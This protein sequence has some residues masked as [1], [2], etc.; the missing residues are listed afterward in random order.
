V[1][2]EFQVRAYGKHIFTCK[3]VCEYKRKLVCGIHVES[4]NPPE[5]PRNVSCIQYGTDGH[6]T[7]TWDKGRPTYIST[8][9]VLQ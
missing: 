4:G 8:E 5:Q 6:P 2:T 1:R 9:Y 7:C 3:M